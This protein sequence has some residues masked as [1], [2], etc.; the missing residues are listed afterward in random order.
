MKNILQLEVLLGYS[1][2]RTIS[3]VT[4]TCFNEN[5]CWRCN[6]SNVFMRQ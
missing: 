2:S 1:G 3:P 4:F 6:G 5:K